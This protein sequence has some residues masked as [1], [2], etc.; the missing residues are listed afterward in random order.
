[1]RAGPAA[2]MTDEDTGLQQVGKADPMKHLRAQAVEHGEADIGAVFGRIVVDPERL[3][4]MS[5]LS[6][7]S[8]QRTNPTRS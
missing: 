5:R 8:C 7:K 6:S 1:M 4:G 3:K 2:G